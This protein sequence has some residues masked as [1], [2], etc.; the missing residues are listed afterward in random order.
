MKIFFKARRYVLPSFEYKTLLVGYIRSA[1]ILCC[2]TRCWMW[3]KISSLFRRSL[4]YTFILLMEW[5]RGKLSRVNGVDLNN[6]IS[7]QHV[8]IKQFFFLVCLLLVSVNM[9]FYEFDWCF[10]FEY[11]DIFGYIF[12]R[13][14][15]GYK[16]LI[17]EIV[18]CMRVSCCE[19]YV[20]YLF[21]NGT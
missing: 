15:S 16:S 9:I 18:I 17:N 20:C 11:E 3:I 5:N 19:T 10:G 2:W 4:L 21:I 1:R 14:T 13:R 12:V 6:D 8:L 7:I